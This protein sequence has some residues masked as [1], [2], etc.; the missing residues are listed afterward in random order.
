MLSRPRMRTRASRV[1]PTLSG[2]LPEEQAGR[3]YFPSIVTV[4]IERGGTVMLKT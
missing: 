1:R 4:F 3:C 2:R